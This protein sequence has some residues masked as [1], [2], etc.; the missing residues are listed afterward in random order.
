LNTV[1]HE[2]DRGK[3]QLPFEIFDVQFL[4]ACRERRIAVKPALQHL[5]AYLF[6]ELADYFLF[7]ALRYALRH[8]YHQRAFFQTRYRGTFAPPGPYDP[9]PEKAAASGAQDAAC[10]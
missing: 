10:S 8:V 2:L 4:R 9:I 1:R 5:P 3:T 7:L 6:L